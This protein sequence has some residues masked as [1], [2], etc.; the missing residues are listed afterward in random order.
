MTWQ[1]Q[2]RLPP[3]WR[4][5]RTAILERDGGLCVLCGAAATDIDHIGPPDD[6][7]PTNLR[8]LCRRCH[9]IRSSRQGNDARPPQPTIRRPRE[10]HPGL[11]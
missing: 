2:R 7:H 4:R 1:G 8:A 9:A 3:G 5:L 10:R 6:H 11:T